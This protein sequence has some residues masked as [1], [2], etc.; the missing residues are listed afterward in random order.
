[1]DF[2]KERKRWILLVVAILLLT[3]IGAG[4]HAWEHECD[5]DPAEREALLA[6]VVWDLSREGIKE[7]DMES[8]KIEHAAGLCAPGDPNRRYQ[9]MVSVKG[10]KHYRLYRWPESAAHKEAG[11][12]WDYGIDKPN[13]DVSE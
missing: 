5:G 4:R 8:I 11:L 12:R 9:A 6:A 7:S 2:K 10:E 3:A 13:P 1:M